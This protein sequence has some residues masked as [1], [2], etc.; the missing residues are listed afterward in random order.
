MP[1]NRSPA[2]LAL[3]CL[4]LIVAAACGDSSTDPPTAHSI[5]INPE[6]FT[7]RFIGDT[8]QASVE[9]RDQSGALMSGQ[10]V[11]WSSAAPQVASVSFNGKLEGESRGATT[12]TASVGAVSATAEVS[13]ISNLTG[14]TFRLHDGTVAAGSTSTLTAV[15]LRGGGGDPG[16][17]ELV[18]SS[19]DTAILTVSGDGETATLTGIAAGTVTVRAAIGAVVGEFQVTVTPAS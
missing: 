17:E 18:W 2:P 5:A 12:V 7:L 13:V 3:L 19:S 14:V 9:V 10:S 11:T 1:A 6:S 16:N 8:A 15:V 4:T